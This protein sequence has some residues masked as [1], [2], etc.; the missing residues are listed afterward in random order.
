MLRV[1]DAEGLNHERA[2]G[3]INASTGRSEATRAAGRGEVDQAAQRAAARL[4]ERSGVWAP[5]T[6]AAAGGW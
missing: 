4:A 2:L 6:T 3:I 1:L 5:L